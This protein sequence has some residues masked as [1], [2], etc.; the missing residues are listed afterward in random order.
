[1]KKK[2]FKIFFFL[3]CFSLVFFIFEK[4]VLA[5][6]SCSKDNINKTITLTLKIAFWSDEVSFDDTDMARWKNQIENI[7]NSGPASSMCDYKINI[8]VETKKVEGVK[9]NYEDGGKSCI[10]SNKGYHCIKI[11]KDC[12]VVRHD[13][14]LG[15][16]LNCGLVMSFNFNQGQSAYGWW[17]VKPTLRTSAHESGHLLG[18]EDEY[19]TS[20][21]NILGNNNIMGVPGYINV[22]KKHVDTLIKNLCIQDDN[23]LCTVGGKIVPEIDPTI[24][25][26]ENALSQYRF[27]F[28]QVL[29]CCQIEK[30]DYTVKRVTNTGVIVSSQTFIVGKSTEEGTCSQAELNTCDSISCKKTAICSAG[31]SCSTSAGA[32]LNCSNPVCQ[33]AEADCQCGSSSITDSTNEWC[34]AATNK[35]YATEADCLRDASCA[36]PPPETLTPTI[37]S[38]PSEPSLTRGFNLFFGISE[39]CKDKGDCSLCHM[40]QILVNVGIFL[41]SFIGAAALLMFVVAGFYF[42]ISAGDQKKISMAKGLIKNTIIG[43]MIVFFAYIF[44]VAFV[45]LLTKNWNWQ[46][47]LGC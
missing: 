1:M 35:V 8:K 4:K 41:L 13:S 11:T 42:L 14:L 38:A 27:K 47:G 37:P 2:C 15:D 23:C 21:V 10:N 36:P 5:S 45:A 33:A 12:E 20:G 22:E 43:L 17:W 28:A 34:C 39:E 24:T 7:W 26:P 16:L 44:I 6:T 19:Y 18:L 29:N 25:P 40:M 32:K 3:L 30:R 9:G 31:C 46:A